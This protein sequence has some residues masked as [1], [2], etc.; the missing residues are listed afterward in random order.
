MYYKAPVLH[1]TARIHDANSLPDE[2]RD[3]REA[4]ERVW[5]RA[6]TALAFPSYSDNAKVSGNGRMTPYSPAASVSSA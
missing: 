4:F 5:S 6:A 3:A 2:A 1:L